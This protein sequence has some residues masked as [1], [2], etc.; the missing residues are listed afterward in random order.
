MKRY[1]GI[2][3]LIALTAAGQTKPPATFSDLSARAQQA[4][5]AQNDAEAKRLF[6]AAVK[7]RPTW[8][9]GW[10]ALGMINYQQDQYAD[11]RDSLKQMVK[12]A[13]KAARLSI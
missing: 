7:L 4:Y 8:T 9:E 3:F 2:L 13:P 11:C 12:L 1:F 5:K 6:T 10:W